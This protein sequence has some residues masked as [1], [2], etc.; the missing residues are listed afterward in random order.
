MDVE[1]IDRDS[2][3]FPSPTNYNNE[4]RGEGDDRG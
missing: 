4:I 2:S 1:T 3:T